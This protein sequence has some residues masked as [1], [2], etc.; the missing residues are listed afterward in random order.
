MLKSLKIKN[1]RC[2]KEFE[3]P[4]LG[5]VNL[6][7]GYN[8]CGKTSILEA[9][10]ILKSLEPSPFLDAA[11]RRRK[12]LRK[13]EKNTIESISHF[14]FGHQLFQKEEIFITGNTNN[15]DI[16]FR[17]LAQESANKP[18][19]PVDVSSR[20][21][22]QNIVFSWDTFDGMEHSSY[23]S[24]LHP[25]KVDELHYKQAKKQN[26]FVAL[27]SSSSDDLINRFNEIVI[28]PQEETLYE[29]L[30]FIE[31]NIRRIAP[32]GN[33]IFMVSINGQ[34]VPIGSMGD[35]IWRMLEIT[36]A[37]VNVSGGILLIDEID[38]G[39]HFSVMLD[40][41]RLICRTA[42]KLDI[43]VFATTHSSDCWKS[44]AEVAQSNEFPET[45]ITIHRIE[46]GKKASVVFN[47][48][49]MAIAAERDIEVR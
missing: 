7:V 6:F 13:I 20:Y 24:S 3:L 2:F 40:L 11:R 17:L 18:M 15:G 9:V 32:V 21:S 1:F 46:K 47:E 49:E 44:L 12:S 42:E 29:A 27:D 35:G 31:P 25:D 23:E 33:G 28:T 8:N 48:Q 36:L 30:R 22:D 19:I 41:W 37:M 5:R 16:T 14:C 38:T 43:Q 10:H 34:R 4:Q 39:L 26:A 45:E